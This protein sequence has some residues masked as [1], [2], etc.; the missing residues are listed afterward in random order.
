MSSVSP[1][2]PPTHSLTLTEYPSPG[3]YKGQV[4]QLAAKLDEGRARDFLTQ[5]S[6]YETRYYKSQTGSESQKWLLDQVNKI[7][8][9]VPHNRKEV[10]VRSVSHPWGQDSII[11]TLPGN[12]NKP[13]VILG[14]HLDSVAG[15]DPYS[16]SPGADDDG[17]GTTTLLE[18]FRVLVESGIKFKNQVEFH[19]YAGEEA[20]LLGSQVVAEEYK[21][22]GVDVKAYLNCDMTGYFPPGDEH[23]GIV[24]DN[25]NKN[26]ADFVAAS[27]TTY[28]GIPARDTNCGY[29]CSDH[30]SWNTS[31]Y[32]AAFSF[33]TEFG[34]HS[35]AIHTSADTI[36]QPGFSF[37]H[38]LNFS[39][40]AI[41]FALELAA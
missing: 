16:R 3:K 37:T 19:W 33:E 32:P 15:R 25:V 4:D 41:A 5:F 39:K 20:G 7:S 9:G 23:V 27:V 17:S 26:L 38:L 10:S 8:E 24:R 18:A 28:L 14:A 36:D 21:R 31:G 12:K 30:A 1:H 29:A 40:L 11:A 13:R 35:P 2:L 6:A 22:Q 34:K